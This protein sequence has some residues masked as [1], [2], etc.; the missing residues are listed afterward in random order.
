MRNERLRSAMVRTHISVED[1]QRAVGV[2]PK[3]VQRW[4]NG[5]VP[6]QRFRWAVAE[7]LDEDEAYL[8]PTTSVETSAGAGSTAEI[9]AVYARR[10]EVDRR[11]WTKLID[12]SRREVCILGYAALFLTEAYPGLAERLVAKAEDGCQ[13]RVALADPSSAEVAARDAEEHQD[14]GLVARIQNALTRFRPVALCEVAD[15]RLHH[16]PMYNSVFRFDDQMVVTPHLFRRGGFESPALHLRRLG[17]HGIFDTFAKHFDEVWSSA[18]AVPS[19][20]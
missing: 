4:L 13:V 12:D 20:A 17:D 9:V 15:L 16:E 14:G 11:L 8:W 1:L 2:D 19:Q 7:L 5:R 10:A 18:I 3:T 6:H